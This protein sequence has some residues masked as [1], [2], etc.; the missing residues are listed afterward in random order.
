MSHTVKRPLNNNANN[1]NL[2][3]NL[4]YAEE[5]GY[6]TP[7]PFQMIVYVADIEINIPAFTKNLMTYLNEVYLKPR[8]LIPQNC[9]TFKAR[10]VDK[11]KFAG[12]DK[13]YE[14]S[15]LVVQGYDDHGK[16]EILTQSPTIQR[17]SQRILFG[18]APIR[19]EYIPP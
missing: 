16:K 15:R 19:H 18:L 14:K 1:K 10:F 5:R 7:R 12:T 17:A 11:V 4:N 9:R 6:A 8:Y 2:N 3:P 13:A